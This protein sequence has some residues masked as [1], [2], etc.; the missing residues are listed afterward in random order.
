MLGLGSKLHKQICHASEFELNNL[1]WKEEPSFAV[2]VQWRQCVTWL[3]ICAAS[4]A[5]DYCQDSRPRVVSRSAWTECSFDGCHR[6]LSKNWCCSLTVWTCANLVPGAICLL[7]IK[8][9]THFLVN[10]TQ[11]I[12][13]RRWIV[14]YKS[15]PCSRFYVARERHWTC[16]MR[17][18]S[19]FPG[20]KRNKLDALALQAERAQ[21]FNRKK[22]R[23]GR[24][25]AGCRLC[26]PMAWVWLAGVWL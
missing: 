22:P 11:L 12:G 3:S 20:G 2:T 17:P 21:T 16:K 6:N 8:N 5:L 25:P 19:E 23:V 7:P 26:K 10:E 4:A 9:S 15:V 18:S 14:L 13:V 1:T 24:Q